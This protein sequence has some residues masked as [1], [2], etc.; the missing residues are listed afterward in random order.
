MVPS[1]RLV[2][3][4]V[5]PARPLRSARRAHPARKRRDTPRTAG[6]VGLL[7]RCDASYAAPP[8]NAAI[9]GRGPYDARGERPSPVKV[10]H[11][12]QPA[13]P[14]QM[15]K[16]T[17][18]YRFVIEASILLL[19]FSMGLSFIAVAPLFPSI[20]EAFKV[21]NATVSLLIGVSSLA[22]AVAL[23]PAS[24]LAARLGSRTALILGG[25]LMGLTGLS[26]FAGSF[27]LLLATRVSFA[28]GAAINLSATPG[29]LLR[30]FS[31]KEL[32]VVNGANVIAQ[33]LGVTTSMLLAPR[34]A[35]L[36]GWDGALSIFGAMALASTVLWLVVGRDTGAASSS[37]PFTMSD[38]PI[39]LGNRVVVLLS[40]A[41]A[42]ALGAF[43][44]IQSWLPTFYSQQWGYSL[45]QAG[46]I[47]GL[48]SFCGIVGALLGSM[49]PIRVPQ[50]RPFLIAGGI[51]IP[52]FAAGAFGMNLPLLIYP[53]IV[54]L[55]VVGWIFVPVVFTIPME[56]PG[57]NASRVGIALAMV[58][59]AGNLAGFVVPLMVGY[60][61]DQTGSFTIGLTIACSL[62]LVMA[63]CA[64]VMPETGPLRSSTHRRGASGVE[65]RSA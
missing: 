49:L 32:A 22:V 7:R 30:W 24:I 13:V 29:V 33:S 14:Q 61:R 63:A 45:E 2:R 28:F 40:I 9:E 5:Y 18:R 54:L 43:I 17:S 25:M 62:A 3:C 20:I 38:L 4:R 46:S 1:V 41:M 11:V 60:L 35:G 64:Y 50:R 31:T 51:G 48:L 55:G 52:L 36:F 10:E 57:M 21:D 53:S 37:A 65:E 59:G 56:I 34:L 42:G 58:L 19:Q 27:P 47:S 26:L 12:T 39:V 44:S 23:I 8:R 6:I 15:T 16:S